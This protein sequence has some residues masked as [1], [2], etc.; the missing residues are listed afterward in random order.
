M[1]LI[2]CN[3][4]LQEAR[5][6]S[7]IPT[8][9]KRKENKSPDIDWRTFC[10][11]RGEVEKRAVD[12]EEGE[13]NKPA[14]QERAAADENFR[15]SRKARYG[16]NRGVRPKDLD[17]ATIAGRTLACEV[18][19]KRKREHLVIHGVGRRN[20]VW[21]RELTRNGREAAINRYRV[22]PMEMSTSSL[23]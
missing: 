10:S 15:E 13:G 18:E 22:K 9:T 2:D 17:P 16:L 5:R 8:G 7:P 12:R 11:A 14:G 19:D 21:E 3:A 4:R 6:K 20:G 23:L 1:G